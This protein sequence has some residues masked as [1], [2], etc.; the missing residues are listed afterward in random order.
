[1]LKPPG[2]PEKLTQQQAETLRDAAISYPFASHDDLVANID[3][4]PTLDKKS[5]TTDTVDI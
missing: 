3:G 5:V 4:I 1:M 2:R